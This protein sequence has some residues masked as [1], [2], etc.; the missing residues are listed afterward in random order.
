MEVRRS[1]RV[2][3]EFLVAIQGLEVEPILRRGNISTTGIYF[4]TSADVGEAGMMSWLQISSVDR[5]RTITVMAY[6]VRRIE[7]T[8]ADERGI[9]GVAFEFIPD[10]YAS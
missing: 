1:A 2:A 9:T 4:V 10:N 8:D 7:L 5:L 6:V 3:S